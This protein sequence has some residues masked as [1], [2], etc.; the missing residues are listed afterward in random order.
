M[1]K[2]LGK[3]R[4]RNKTTKQ[5]RQQWLGANAEFFMLASDDGV[6][7]KKNCEKVNKRMITRN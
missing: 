3:K 2:V 1:A 6:L 5:Q 4:N 7:L